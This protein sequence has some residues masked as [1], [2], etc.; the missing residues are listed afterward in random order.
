MVVVTPQLQSRCWSP[1]W[2]PP[3]WPP[4]SAWLSEGWMTNLS[5]ALCCDVWNMESDNYFQF[6]SGNLSKNTF[7][8]GC[9]TSPMHDGGGHGQGEDLG[10]GEDQELHLKFLCQMFNCQMQAKCW[11]HLSLP[12]PLYWTYRVST[13]CSASATSWWESALSSPASHTCSCPPSP[14]ACNSIAYLHD[15]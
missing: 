7:H 9:L 6:S 11:K 2:A 5:S 1:C 13:S 15:Q 12:A 14:T 8:V 3:A 4:P 10:L